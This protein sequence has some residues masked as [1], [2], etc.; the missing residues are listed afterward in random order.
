MGG[1]DTFGHVEAA[2]L[3]LRVLLAERAGAAPEVDA[4][5][6][7]GGLS[8]AVLRP[9]GG[10]LGAAVQPLPAYR[11]QQVVQCAT[12][13][14]RCKYAMQCKRL[15][16]E[17]GTG[18]M[19]TKTRGV[20]VVWE[21]PGVERVHVEPLSTI[22]AV[23]PNVTQGHQSVRQ[24]ANVVDRR[25]GEKGRRAEKHASYYVPEEEEEERERGRESSLL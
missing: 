3:Q 21:W 6:H 1:A 14:A 9:H 2:F 12:H 20:V 10:A 18:E 15:V 8:Q 4:A 24:P 25:P 7:A 17:Y 13:A 19:E 22:S 23:R 11:R 16:W 5:V